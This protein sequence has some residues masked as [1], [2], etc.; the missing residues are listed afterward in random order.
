MS[1]DLKKIEC[2]PKCGFVIHS[3]D[4]KVV[5]EIARKHAK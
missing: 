2:D 3:H 4:E 5:L 1:N